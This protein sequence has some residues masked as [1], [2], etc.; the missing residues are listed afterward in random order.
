GDWEQVDDVSAY[1]G[2]LTRSGNAGDSVTFTFNG[3]GLEVIAPQGSDYGLAT[4]SLDGGATQEITSWYYTDQNAPTQ[5]VVHTVSGLAPGQHTVT[6]TV[7]GAAAPESTSGGTTVAIDALDVLGGSSDGGIL[8]NDDA[9][10]ITYSD[11]HWT[12][13]TGQAWTAGDINGDETFSNLAGASFEFEFEGVG[14]QLIAAHSSNH[15]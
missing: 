9:D 7:A 15:G 13:A 8:I 6:I 12:Y 2:T 14:F 11:G 4:I 3:T 10:F 1:E 5:S